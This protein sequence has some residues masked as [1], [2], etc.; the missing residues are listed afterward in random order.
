MSSDL[1]SSEDNYEKEFIDAGAFGAVFKITFKNDRKVFALKQID[2]GKYSKNEM[3]AILEE[4]KEEYN[5]M[6]LGIPN[7]LRSFGS[8]YD[9]EKNHFRFSI[10]L[11]E[12]NLQKHV[13][14]NGALSFD[15]FLII[16]GDVIT[17]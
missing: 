15:N 3:T 12:T 9:L 1:L 2:L 13:A 11:M 4:A 10:E 7:V 6:L 5:T 8:H 16:F 14:K 17:G